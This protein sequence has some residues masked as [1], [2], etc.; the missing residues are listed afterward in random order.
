MKSTRAEFDKDSETIFFGGERYHHQLNQDRSL[1]NIPDLENM[2]YETLES[3]SETPENESTTTQSISK[4]TS[5]DPRWG[6]KYNKL[7]DIWNPTSDDVDDDERWSVLMKKAEERQ[8]AKIQKEEDKK[9][10]N[11]PTRVKLYKMK[12]DSVKIQIGHLKIVDYAG[13]LFNK[14]WIEGQDIQA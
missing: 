14:K 5:V 7:E 1:A 2:N 8:R 4:M 10:K 6:D 3:L 12:N 13:C 11:I 9:G